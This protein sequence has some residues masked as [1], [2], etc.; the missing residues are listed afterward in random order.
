[1]GPLDLPEFLALLP[2]GA[3]E[4]PAH[5]GE[6]DQL[7]ELVDIMNSD[8]LEYEVTLILRSEQVP[9]AQLGSGIEGADHRNHTRLGWCSWLGESSGED[10][11][12][13]FRFK[14]WNHGRG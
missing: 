5:A 2:R 13:T 10:R 14:G 12:V 3:D 11:N 9:R 4:E 1:M 8:G 7:R 6:L